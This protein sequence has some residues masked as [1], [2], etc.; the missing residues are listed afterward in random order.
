MTDSTPSRDTQAMLLLGG[1]FAPKEQANPLEPRELNRVIDFLGERDRAMETL[2]DQPLTRE[3]WLSL[4]LDPAR[5]AS[6]LE[7]KMALGLAVERWTN[8]GLWVISRCDPRYPARLRSHL[9][10]SA[11]PL[12]WG[13]GDLAIFEGDCVAIVGSRE[14]DETDSE[15]TAQVAAAIA[16]EGLTVVSGGARGVDQIAMASALESSGRVIAVLAEG[17]GKPSVASKYREAV[18]EQ[19]LLLLSPF[20]PDA[21]FTVGSAMSRNKVIYGLARAAIITRAEANSG[22]TWAGAEEELR[23]AE[24]IPLFVRASE[25]IAEGNQALIARGARP[26]PPPPWRA[27]AEILFASGAAADVRPPQLSLF[28]S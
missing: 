5:G 22:G 8:G 21:G 24:R 11:P 2:L 9:G 6:L 14:V 12:L 3:E 4:D 19:R 23:R 13:V 18:M 1:R 26:F 20:Y 25:P 28:S 27:L 7:R 17:L 15:W 10:R 16:Q